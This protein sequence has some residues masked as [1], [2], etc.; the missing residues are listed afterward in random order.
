MY[1]NQQGSIAQQLK[2]ELKSRIGEL[3][4][5][6]TIGGQ[7]PE[8]NI[9][10]GTALRCRSG[11]C[12]KS[13]RNRFFGGSVITERLYI[14]KKKKEKKNI[15]VPRAV[16]ARLWETF[17]S[18]ERLY[19]KAQMKTAIELNGVEHS[20]TAPLKNYTISRTLNHSKHH[21]DIK[22]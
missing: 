3:E 7:K 17:T 11:P 8:Y 13:W 22:G 9:G 12:R 5:K 14:K 20:Q 4:Q 21:L 1:S 6:R 18:S 15:A 16:A 19:K 2:I 10:D